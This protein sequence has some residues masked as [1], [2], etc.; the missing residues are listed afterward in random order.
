MKISRILA[1]QSDAS[2]NPSQFILS[3]NAALFGYIVADV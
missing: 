1:G 3:L 2:L